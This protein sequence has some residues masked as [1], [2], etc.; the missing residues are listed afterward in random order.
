MYG[1]VLMGN[2]LDYYGGTISGQADQTHRYREVNS[3]MSD[4]SSDNFIGLLAHNR[5]LQG[6]S[7]GYKFNFYE[8]DLG[9]YTDG[10]V[11][12]TNGYAVVAHE[13]NGTVAPK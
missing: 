4:L 11:L 2:Q 1:D 3:A 12:Y 9:P 13:P 6:F 5:D 8:T 10:N 7:I